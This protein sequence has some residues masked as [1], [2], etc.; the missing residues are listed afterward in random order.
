MKKTMIFTFFLLLPNLLPSLGKAGLLSELTN[1]KADQ[2]RRT[3]T[4]ERALTR[5]LPSEIDSLRDQFLEARARTD[6]LDRYIFFTD[7]HFKG[8]DERKFFQFA[9]LSLAEK[10]IKQPEYSSKSLWLFLKNFAQIVDQSREAGQTPADLLASYLEYSPILSPKAPNGF[11]SKM[12]YSN[13]L[14]FEA[15]NT[16]INRENVAESVEAE[17]KNT[18]SLLPLAAPKP[19]PVV[20]IESSKTSEIPQ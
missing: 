4:L 19:R 13:G 8:G 5:A 10:E 14:Q 6:L 7:S 11:L 1:M 12:D 16:N 15:V 9:T 3:K 20:L 2:F 18:K 17:L